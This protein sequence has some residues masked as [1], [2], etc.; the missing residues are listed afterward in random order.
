MPRSEPGAA[1]RDIT[2]CGQWADHL[3]RGALDGIDP[4]G[5][6]RPRPARPQQGNATVGSDLGSTTRRTRTPGT[7]LHPHG[8]GSLRWACV[9]AA[10]RPRSLNQNPVAVP[11]TVLTRPTAWHPSTSCRMIVDPDGDPSSPWRRIQPETANNARARPAGS[12]L[13][14]HPGTRPQAGTYLCPMGERWSRRFRNSRH[15]AGLRPGRRPLTVLLSPAMTSGP[16]RSCPLTVCRAREGP[17]NDVRIPTAVTTLTV[18][19]GRIRRERGGSDVLITGDDQY[20]A[21]SSTR[22][23]TY[24]PGRT[25]PS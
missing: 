14:D 25:P 17:D 5:D 11:D 8:R 23:R 1:P 7:D 19:I 10:I 6:S 12:V 2:A 22:S 21:W 16:T 4:D 24:R 15:R 20:S 9:Y 18:T 13:L 3:H